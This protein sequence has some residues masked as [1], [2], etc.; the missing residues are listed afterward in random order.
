M[1][2]LFAIPIENGRLCSHFGRCESFA[3]VETE[4]GKVIGEKFV[5][6]PVHEPGSYP[7]F[8]AS[9]GVSTIISGG[10]GMNAQHLFFQNNIE[11]CMGVNSDTPIKLVENY[12]N[13]LLVT[14]ENLCDSGH[15]GNGHNHHH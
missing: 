4:E 3:I 2:K 14:G 12:L 6:P 9:L 5:N 15:L 8:L 1:K 7:R 11:V 10:M 13:N